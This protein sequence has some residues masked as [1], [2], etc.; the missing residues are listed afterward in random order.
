MVELPGELSRST[1]GDVLGALHRSSATGALNL[2]EG[3]ERKHWIYL[4]TGLVHDVD[5]P[6][7]VTPLSTLLQSSAARAPAP[8]GAE[9]SPVPGEGSM[10]LSFRRALELAQ[11]EQM[12][13]KLES[14][15]AIR[16]ARLR[17]RVMQRNPDRSTR[18]LEPAEFLHGRTRTRDTGLR[19]LERQADLLLLGL[20]VN[21]NG[22]LV[23][24]HFRQLARRWHPDLHL[25]R[26]ESERAA[27]GL[28]FAQLSAA[29]QRLTR[30]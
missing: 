1:L 22:V 14:L 26:S 28:R 7:A 11:R 20:P 10:A 25:H 6:G 17:F 21:A 30:R 3:H 15:F 29:Y 4:R 19:P 16:R 9:V 13:Q 27:L 18:P 8:P 2:E 24:K 23:R 12:R 5:S